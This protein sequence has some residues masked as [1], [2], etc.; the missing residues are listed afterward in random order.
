MPSG[1][2]PQ[3]NRKVSPQKQDDGYWDELEALAHGTADSFS[4]GLADEAAGVIGATA[5]Y[6]TGSMKGQSWRE[7]RLAE[8]ERWRQDQE[9][10]K[11]AHPNIYLAGQV[12]GMLPGGASGLAVKGARMV[13]KQG[14]RHMPKMT[15]MVQTPLNAARGVAARHV[16]EKLKPIV[17]TAG[18]GMTTGAGLGVLYGFNSG[19][20]GFLNRAA[21]MPANAVAVGGAGT[22][23]APAGLAVGRLT[24]AIGKS[25]APQLKI[26]ASALKKVPPRQLRTYVERAG[27]VLAADQMMRMMKEE[28]AP[29]PRSWRERKVDEAYSDVQNR[30]GQAHF[31]RWNGKW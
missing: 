25:G 1:L 23:A 31:S 24:Q 7:T 15:Q 14:A 4:L 21:N 8:Q 2:R 18:K 9:A 20:G 30:I 11:K 13:A 27:G 29:D 26:L 22:I 5:K 28:K 6:L 17:R 12:V 3:P 10:S 19:N 16:P